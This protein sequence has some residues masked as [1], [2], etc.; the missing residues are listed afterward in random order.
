MFSVLVCTIYSKETKLKIGAGVRIGWIGR[1][2]RMKVQGTCFYEWQNLVAEASRKGLFGEKEMEW[3]S[4][5]ILD[6]QLE[7]EWLDGIEQRKRMPRP[8]GRKRE[9]KSPEQRRKIAEAIAAKWADPVSGPDK[10][11]TFSMLRTSK[12]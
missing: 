1:R 6:E 10:A 3:N 4:Y 2:K 7:K 12:Y 8:K 5:K 9:R 11:F